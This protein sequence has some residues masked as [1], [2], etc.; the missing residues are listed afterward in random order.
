MCRVGRLHAVLRTLRK[1]T[2]ALIAIGIVALVGATGW[3]ITARADHGALLDRTTIG[4]YV[5]GAVGLA[6]E[7]SR[8]S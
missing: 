2:K 1:W 4:G 5:L 8:F 6:V 7:C 3:V